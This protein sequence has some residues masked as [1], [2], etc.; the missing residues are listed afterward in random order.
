MTRT[1]SLDYYA[2]WCVVANENF[3]AV[4]HRSPMH[5]SPTQ[6]ARGNKTFNDTHTRLY[7]QRC[8]S[9]WQSLLCLIDSQWNVIT[10]TIT[11]RHQ[12][13]NLKAV[14]W[15]CWWWLRYTGNLLSMALNSNNNN[16]NIITRNSIVRRLS[17]L[18]ERER[19]KWYY[20]S[21]ANPLKAI[22]S[23]TSHNSIF[24]NRHPRPPTT[25]PPTVH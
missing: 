15:K 17:A 12:T 11:S 16:N 7:Q 23:L 22:E 2:T 21:F 9:S 4:T 5:M 10:S 18:N 20:Q 1:D 8:E 13:R 25:H 3:M 6:R 14:R 24:N 19:T